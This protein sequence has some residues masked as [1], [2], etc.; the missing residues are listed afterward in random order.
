[1]TEDDPQEATDL[2]RA[3]DWRIK[4]L[5]ENPADQQSATAARLLQK[6]AAD[7][8]RRRGSPAYTDYLAILN[9]LG[10]FDVIDDFA[11]RAHEYRTRIA[12]DHWPEDGEAYLRALIALAK[13][14]AGG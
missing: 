2:D 5:G 4:K 14:V 13:D 3:A 11:E 12:I 7:V 10:E 8:R 1:M 9:W 6:L